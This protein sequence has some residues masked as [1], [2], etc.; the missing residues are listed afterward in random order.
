MIIVV[1][2]PSFRDKCNVNI[3][4]IEK[5]DQVNSE[6]YNIKRN[7]RK[8]ENLYKIKSSNETYTTFVNYRYLNIIYYNC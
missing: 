7:V 4:F 8:L 3:I 1:F 2:Q 6:L 5:L